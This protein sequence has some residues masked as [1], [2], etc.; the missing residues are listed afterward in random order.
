KEVKDVVAYLKLLVN[1]SDEVA[2]KR[3]VNMPPRGIGAGTLEVLETLVSREGLSFPAAAAAA[4][5][6][7]LL[8]AR[9]ERALREFLDL[10]EDFRRGMA[11]RSAGEITAG[12]IEKIGFREYLERAHPQDSESRIENLEELVAAVGEDEGGEEG[13]QEFLQRTALFSEV[14]NTLGSEGISLMTLHSAKGLEFPTVFLVG[15]EEG[16]FPHAHGQESA[17]DIEEERRLC[18]VGMTRAE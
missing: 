11:D 13:I 9:G 2:W 8:T 16:L 7:S 3:S 1:P 10:L 15:M 18:Y 6:R 4:R 5:D 14:E 17:E 12:L